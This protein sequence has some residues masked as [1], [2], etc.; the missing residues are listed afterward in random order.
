M[1]RSVKMIDRTYGHLASDSAEAIRARLNARPPQL[2]V[3]WAS[4]SRSQSAKTA[5]LQDGSDGTRTRDL[6]RDRPRRPSRRMA[7]EDANRLEFRR[8]S[9]FSTMRRQCP[10]EAAAG[11]LGHYR[12]TPRQPPRPFLDHVVRDEAT[13][14]RAPNPTRS[15]RR[16]SCLKPTHAEGIGCRSRVLRP[17]ESFDVP[18]M[19]DEEWEKFVAALHE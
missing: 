10:W 7:T 17:D 18:D 3:S 13:E 9:V 4:D 15:N 2:G 14:D 12:A 16:T 1:Q 5:R 11:R 6:R 19:T 8:S